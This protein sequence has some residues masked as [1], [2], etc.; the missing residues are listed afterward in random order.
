MHACCCLPGSQHPC[1]SHNFLFNLIH[2]QIILSYCGT[3]ATDMQGRMCV[4]SISIHI[5][6]VVE[7]CDADHAFSGVCNACIALKG[8]WTQLHGRLAV[9]CMWGSCTI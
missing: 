2:A 6:E 4:P 9:R 5:W 3:A 8:V 1:L 7:R